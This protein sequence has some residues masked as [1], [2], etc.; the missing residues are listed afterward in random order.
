MK[1]EQHKVEWNKF[2]Q[3]K[4]D[5]T[6]QKI[7]DCIDKKYT[8]KFQVGLGGFTNSTFIELNDNA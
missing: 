5:Y 4:I 7:V 2:E 8:N 1:Y 6:V 3:I